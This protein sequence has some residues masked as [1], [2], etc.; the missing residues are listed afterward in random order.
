M[1]PRNNNKPYQKSVRTPKQQPK[2]NIRKNTKKRPK[3]PKMSQ[4][5]QK[6]ENSQK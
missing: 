1:Y 3:T 2:A 4:N 5:D 6:H